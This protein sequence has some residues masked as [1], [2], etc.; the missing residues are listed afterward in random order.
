MSECCAI[1]AQVEVTGVVAAAMAANSPQ[2][3]RRARYIEAAYF[4]SARGYGDSESLRLEALKGEL[5]AHLAVNRKQSQFAE[6]VL[7]PGEPP[8]LW[9]DLVTS[10]VMEPDY[11]TY[12][13]EQELNGESSILLTTGR[14]E[15]VLRFLQE[16]L[17]QRASL[18]S[19]AISDSASAR[20]RDA[21][22]S[23]WSTGFVIYAWLTGFVLGLLIILI[24]IN[25]LK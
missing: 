9:I 25:V 24:A 15:Q 23:H 7:V 4:D 3:M 5:S 18:R 13:V 14:R 1:L 22:S 11:R 10:V 17:S 16:Y 2:D 8:R 6:L 21:G 12:Q 19:D 20:P